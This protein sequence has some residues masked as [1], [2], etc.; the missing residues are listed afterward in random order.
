M[1]LTVLPAIVLAGCTYSVARLDYRTYP[2][3]GAVRMWTSRQDVKGPNLGSVEATRSGW[4]DCDAMATATTLD[5]LEQ[6]RA[7]GGDG[8]AATR[9]QNPSHWA[10]RPRCRRNWV[11]LGHMTVHAIGIA[12]K[13]SPGTGPPSP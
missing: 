7:V 10:G 5:L 8:V 9:F 6:A 12:V 3:L 11:L 4:T 13:N 1:T 2:E